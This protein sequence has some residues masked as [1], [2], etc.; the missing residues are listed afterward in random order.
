MSE[1]D[2]GMITCVP[3]TSSSSLRTGQTWG[4]LY[5]GSEGSDKDSQQREAVRVGPDEG[6]VPCSRS[7]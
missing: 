4:P 7:Q 3:P 5:Y 2:V 6:T 1:F